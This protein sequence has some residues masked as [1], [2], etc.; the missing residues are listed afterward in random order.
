M[1]KSKGGLELLE[2]EE[3][4]HTLMAEWMVRTLH[5]GTSNL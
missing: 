3:S 4:L 1:E 2:V 5:R